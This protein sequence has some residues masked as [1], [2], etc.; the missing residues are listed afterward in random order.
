MVNLLANANRYGSGGIIVE[1][2]SHDGQMT[3]VVSNEGNPIP[4]NALPTLFDPL[5][6]ASLPNS[7]GPV[8]GIGLGLYTCRGN[9]VADQGT[10]GVSRSAKLPA[11]PCVCHVRRRDAEP[12]WSA[13][14]GA[15]HL[16]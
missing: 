8:A 12:G 3:L 14:S 16:R 7:N 1:A 15:L 9:A 13:F 5:R 10:S 11:S 2:T 4:E 6:R